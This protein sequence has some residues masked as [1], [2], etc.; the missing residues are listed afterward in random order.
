V[1]NSRLDTRGNTGRDVRMDLPSEVCL[2]DLRMCTRLFE[3]IFCA[4]DMND[5]K[6]KVGKEGAFEK[7]VA[8]F[9]KHL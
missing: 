6:V 3:F 8:F 2:D 9:K 5:P 1:A 7:S 4:G